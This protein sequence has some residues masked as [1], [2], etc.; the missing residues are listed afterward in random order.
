MGTA[1]RGEFENTR[2][3]ST[4]VWFSKVI[5]MEW[6]KWGVGRLR[7]KGERSGGCRGTS[8]AKNRILNLAS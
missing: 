1:L 7:C 6:R 8:E 5:S 3:G 4:L 2:N